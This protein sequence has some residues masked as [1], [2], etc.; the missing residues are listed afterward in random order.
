MHP[1]LFEIGSVKVYSYGAAL[2]LAFFLGA[3]LA[4][5]EAPR[6]G[7]EQEKILDLSILIGIGA[8]VGSRIAYIILDLPYYLETPMKIISREGG[9]S[10]HGG[11]IAGFLI[12]FWYLKRHKIPVGVTADLI[13]PYV[14]LGYAITRI[15]CLMYGCC[16][17][18]VSNLP[19]ALASSFVD[20]ALRHPTQIYASLINFVFFGLLLY[21]RDKKPFHGYLF[22]LYVGFYGLY[23]FGIEFFRD[24]DVFFGPVTLAQAI[25]LLMIL[26]SALLIRLWPWKQVDKIS[27]KKI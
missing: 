8:L 12:S 11:L 3:V 20:N 10:F 19:W 25:S 7:I 6:V 2:A 22:V 13:A 5:R 16:Y 1:V 9:L 17:G 18:K 4:M 15:G 14:A 21:L 23:R 24:S 26:A 27:D